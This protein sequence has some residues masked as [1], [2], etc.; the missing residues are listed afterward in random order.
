MAFLLTSISEIAKMTKY[1]GAINRLVNC[2]NKRYSAENARNFRKSLNYAVYEALQQKV[3]RGGGALN[4]QDLPSQLNTLNSSLFRSL[5]VENSLLSAVSRLAM[6]V[7][8][9]R[10]CRC[11]V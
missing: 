4:L 10:Q 1:K 8:A 7:L 9:T 5:S 2:N 3:Y 11:V 6:L